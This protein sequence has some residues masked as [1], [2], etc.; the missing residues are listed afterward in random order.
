MIISQVINIHPQDAD[1][2]YSR[3]NSRYHL[4]DN[5]G[6]MADFQKSTDIYRQQGKLK[7]HKNARQR[8][9]DL[10]IEASLDILNF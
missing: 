6:S 4:G 2:Y 9:L 10:E 8:I 7:E 5:Q 3:G 1:A